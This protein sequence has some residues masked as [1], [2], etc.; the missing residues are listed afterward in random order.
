MLLKTAV[1]SAIL[2]LVMVAGVPFLVYFMLSWRDRIGDSFLR[3][4]RGE[5][6]L[7][8]ERAWIGSLVSQRSDL[9]GQCRA[10][11]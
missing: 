10:R 1:F 9:Y 4:F 11:S 8:V 5:Q 6:K 7:T 2:N 3:L